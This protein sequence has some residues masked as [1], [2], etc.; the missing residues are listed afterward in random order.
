MGAGAIPIQIDKAFRDRVKGRHK[1]DVFIAD[2][3]YEGDDCVDVSIQGGH[4]IMT[5][6]KHLLIEYKLGKIDEARFQEAFFDYLEKSFVQHQHTWD[7]ILDKNKIVLICSCNSDDKSCHRYF[8]IKF[9]KM[10]G[11]VYKGKLK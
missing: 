6:P 2:A 4:F 11:A 9:L 10:F 8:I 3:G 5:P 7:N 1:L